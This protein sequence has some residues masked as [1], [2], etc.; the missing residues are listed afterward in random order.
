MFSANLTVPPPHLVPCS[1]L[2][3]TRCF[4]GVLAKPFRDIL[5]QMTNGL[6]S[7]S[8]PWATRARGTRRSLTS[9]S[10]VYTTANVASA[11]RTTAFAALTWNGDLE[12][13]SPE[14]VIQITQKTNAVWKRGEVSGEGFWV[15]G[16]VAQNRHNVCCL[17]PCDFPHS[18]SR[19]APGKEREG[20]VAYV[21]Q[22]PK[23]TSS[24]YSCLPGTA[25]PCLLPRTFY[26]LLSTLYS[27]KVFV[28]SFCLVVE[29][30]ATF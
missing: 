23:T 7:T 5:A 20:S 25:V 16:L 19:S 3:P 28:L 17:Q 22:A 18:F 12:Q 13:L 8:V 15:F 14:K 26:S 9:R 29:M 4:A 24:T 27:P 10:F 2:C 11:L 1:L 6:H 21:A 30:C